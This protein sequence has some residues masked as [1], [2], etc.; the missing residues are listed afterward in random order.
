MSPRLIRAPPISK[1]APPSSTHPYKSRR[2][3]GGRVFRQSNLGEDFDG[4]D[5][6]DHFSCT[7]PGSGSS[8][9]SKRL[10]I[11]LKTSFV[12]FVIHHSWMRSTA[13]WFSTTSFA[14]S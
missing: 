7:V 3:E 4:G 2:R 8:F 10:V 11:S 9:G 14:G 12:R 13:L 1:V 6:A 5:R